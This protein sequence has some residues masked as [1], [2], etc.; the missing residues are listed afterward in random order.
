MHLGAGRDGEGAVAAQCTT[1]ALRPCQQ[2][3]RRPSPVR[4]SAGLL[5]RAAHM[6]AP[7][8]P[9]L[10][11]HPWLTHSKQ[12]AASGMW[13]AMLATAAAAAVAESV[14]ATVA[15]VAPLL[16]PSAVFSS[17]PPP[18]LLAWGVCMGDATPA[19]AA[20]E[21]SC[22]VQ[23]SHRVCEPYGSVRSPG[24]CTGCAP[25]WAFFRALAAEAGGRRRF[26]LEASLVPSQGH[27]VAPSHRR[28][29][30]STTVPSS[31]CKLAYQQAAGARVPR[32]CCVGW[33]RCNPPAG[34]S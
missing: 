18:S 15:V 20:D 3:A 5:L 32:P 13:P 22:T 11:L 34:S 4:P 29:C 14:C 10:L 17:P 7:C 1:S 23:A 27:D 9:L 33:V 21:Q 19:A 24:K 30:H 6:A 8:Q 25:A 12:H 28:D 16:Q 2:L 31:L 26:G